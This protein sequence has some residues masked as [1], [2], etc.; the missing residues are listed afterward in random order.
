P[1]IVRLAGFV[2]LTI[3]AGSDL[4]SHTVSHTVPSAVSGLNSVFGMGT[5]VT[6]ILLPPASLAAWGLGLPGAPHQRRLARSRS[7]PRQSFQNLSEP[8][9]KL[10]SFLQN[11]FQKVSSKELFQRLFKERPA[12]ARCAPAGRQLNILQTVVLTEPAH[13]AFLRASESSGA[14]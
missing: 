4:L 9:L 13:A 14:E 1:R 7:R 11:L 5:G 6:L 10:L 8:F 3:N 2:C 12:L